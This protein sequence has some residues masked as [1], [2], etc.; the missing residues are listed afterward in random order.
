LADLT[1]E[2]LVE[3]VGHAMRDAGADDRWTIRNV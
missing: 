1:F 2:Q 3:R